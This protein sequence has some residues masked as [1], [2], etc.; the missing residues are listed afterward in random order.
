MKKA[1]LIRLVW[2]C[3]FASVLS[4]TAFT[5]DKPDGEDYV[6]AHYTKYEYRI[7]MRDGV[8]LFTRVFVPKDDS[9]PWPI[10]LSRTPYALRPYG[11]DNFMDLAGS[12]Y[13]T[14]AKDNFI[15]VAQ[16]VRGRFGSEGT[17]VHVRPFNP[18][19]GPKDTDESTDTWDTIDW[20]VKNVPNNNGNV[21]MFG[22]S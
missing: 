12:S 10:I 15:L 16:D 19:K 2:M 11:T 9:S 14:L 1:C 4:T 17:Y 13:A 18:N 22:I 20:L 6:K 8:H 21:G 7:P 5:Q 3:L